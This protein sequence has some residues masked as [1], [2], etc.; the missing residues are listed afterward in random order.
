MP[1]VVLK[2][3][4]EYYNNILHGGSN[5]IIKKGSRIIIPET[6]QKI[7]LDQLHYSHQGVE[8]TAIKVLK[9]HVFKPEMQYTGSELMQISRT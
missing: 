5:G 3:N 1:Y 9:K 6:Q 2:P 8:K 7:I 4:N